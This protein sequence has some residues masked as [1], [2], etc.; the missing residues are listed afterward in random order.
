MTDKNKFIN[1]ISTY[2]PPLSKAVRTSFQI[3][4]AQKNLFLP[5]LVGGLAAMNPAYGAAVEKTL[6]QS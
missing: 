6:E 1:K 2:I 3:I 4:K 5:L